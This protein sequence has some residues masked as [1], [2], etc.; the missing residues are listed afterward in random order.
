M[1]KL[2]RADFVR[3]KKSKIFFTGLAVLVVFGILVAVNNYRLALKFEQPLSEAFSECLF[4]SVI[5]FGI[6]FAVFC[7]LFVGTEYDEGTIRNKLIIGRSRVGIYLS[8]MLSCLGAALSQA[9]VSVAAVVIVGGI[10]YGKPDMKAGT[11][12][13]LCVVSLFLCMAY[14]SLYNMCAMLIG[15]KSH[16]AVIN[17]LLA[18]AFLI[19]A[20]YMAARL[21]EPEMMTQFEM[22]VDGI[23]VMGDKTPNPHYIAGGKRAV[24]QFLLDF[25]P[26]GQSFQI[27]NSSMQK[28]ILHH[29]ALSCIYSVVIT[30]VTNVAGILMFCRKDIK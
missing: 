6:I 30:A 28:Q 23:S 9:I 18:F 27:A 12:F 15:S 21:D 7:S 8:N 5:L 1:R 13:Q 3:M 2:L 29:P 14:V 4:Q 24:Y 17:I 26:G 19:I 25:L 11:F 16:T 22:S 10:L 20:T